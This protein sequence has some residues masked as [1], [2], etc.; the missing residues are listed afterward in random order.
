MSA[1]QIQSDMRELKELTTEIKRMKM[2]LKLLNLKK[3]EIEDR[4][5]EYLDRNEQPGIKYQSL[6]VLATE[7][8]VRKRKTVEERA[9]EVAQI[10]EEKGFHDVD[11]TV[12][13]I[14]ETL[15]GR[16]QTTMALKI[17]DDP[18][19]PVRI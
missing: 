14:M 8:K 4:I 1:H 9:N 17:K 5:K 6:V 3:R 13:E 10:L 19:K 18:N 16:A 7:K 11:D 12:L 15:K 2:T